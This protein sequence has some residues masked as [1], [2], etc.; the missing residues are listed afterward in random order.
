MRQERTTRGLRRAG[1]LRIEDLRKGFAPTALR[2]VVVHAP[3]DAPGNPAWLSPGRH[4]QLDPSVDEFGFVGD[5]ARSSSV[6][7]GVW[8]D[9]IVGPRLRGSGQKTGCLVQSRSRR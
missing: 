4:E 9:A 2:R 1:G 6:A 8:T 5:T 3:I 7:A